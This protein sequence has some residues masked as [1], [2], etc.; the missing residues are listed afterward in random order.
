M[1]NGVMYVVK[2]DLPPQMVTQIGLEVFARWM[3]FALGKESIGGRRL[4]YPTG[5]YAA[6]LQFKKTGEA[7]VAIIAD[8]SVA[9]EAAIL[10]QGHGPVDLKTRLAPG[11]YPMHRTPGGKPG[12]GLRRT[13]SKKGPFARASMWAR[14][15][16][17]EA[18]GFA[19]IG[20][21]SAPGSWII[22][23]M[24]PYAPAATLANMI[25]AMA[26]RGA[27]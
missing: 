10:E 7:S 3:D 24:A 27:H 17:A 20:P 11:R 21:N 16:A 26:T 5:R 9:P 25:R 19:S 1:T 13:G 4:I 23:A 8:E 18:N 6:S 2:T 15:R 14:V 12:T 22:P